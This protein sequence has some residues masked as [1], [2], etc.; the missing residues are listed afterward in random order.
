MTTTKHGRRPPMKPRRVFVV[1]DHDLVRQGIATI[2]SDVDDLEFV[3]EAG[4]VSEALHRMDRCAP[5][6]AVV[7]LQL[8]DDSG[9]GLIRD[10]RIR[11]PKVRILVLSIRDEGFYAER[12]L[13]AGA[14]GYLTKDAGRE[15]ILDGIRKVLAGQICISEEMT[16]RVMSRMVDGGG[17]ENALIDGLTDRELE[18]FEWIG[19]GIPT[20]DIAARLHISRKT[21]DSHRE[22]I[23][24]KLHLQTAAELVK[25]AIE[26]VR[27]DGSI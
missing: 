8:G 25:Q 3:G 5:D 26:W 22:N 2:L 21:V 17:C 18:I 7:D 19:R 27:R 15:R 4:G 6:V 1:D 14:R 12:V 24:Q 16:T 13:R 10:I 9:L 20:R 11:F 23:K